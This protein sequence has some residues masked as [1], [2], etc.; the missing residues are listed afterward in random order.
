MSEIKELRSQKRDST[1]DD[2]VNYGDAKRQRKGHV[3]R[4]PGPNQDM[5]PTSDQRRAQERELDPQLIYK[6]HDA[7]PPQPSDHF[8]P[9]SEPFRPL[10]EPASDDVAVITMRRS[11]P[12]PLTTNGLTTKDSAGC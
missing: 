2:S 9:L 4:K 5:S 6:N 8:S 11:E 1:D 3:Q 7:L 10:S 12:E